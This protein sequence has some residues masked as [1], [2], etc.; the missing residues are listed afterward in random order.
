[1]MPETTP[2]SLLSSSAETAETAS[3]SS[4]DRDS[5]RCRRVPVAHPSTTTTT[6]TTTT[7]NPPS[8][9]IYALD[10]DG[11][12]VDSA[13]E[14]CESA[15]RAC[16]TVWP[17]DIDI[18]LW[19]TP[20]QTNPLV[21]Q[22]VL[23]QFY[24]V[25]PILYVGWEAILLV[26]LLVMQCSSQSNDDSD[27]DNETDDTRVAHPVTFNNSSVISTEDIVKTFHSELKE[28]IM[29]YYNLSIKD[30]NDA[31]AQARN[32]W[33]NENTS[34]DRTTDNQQQQPQPQQRQYH[35]QRVD[36]IAAH[37]F[38]EGACKAVREYLSTHGND[39]IY[40]ITT[41]AKDFT[42]RLLQKQNLYPA[43]N[44]NTATTVIDGDDDAPPSSSYCFLQESHIYGL[45][46]GPKADVLL[47]IMDQ[48]QRQQGKRSKDNDNDDDDDD[49]IAVMIEDNIATLQTIMSM[50]TTHQKKI[51]P[52]VAAW[53]YNTDD[54]L[55]VAKRDG[56][57]LLKEDDSSSL[58]TILDERRV[59]Q[60][61]Q[62]FV[63]S[64]RP[65][66]GVK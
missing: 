64:R 7:T 11:V 29:K 56:Y 25:R 58:S 1:M 51:L 31:F 14:T 20:L 5:D 10:F 50:S 49:V 48:R 66:S 61:Y 26:K 46:S 37:G 18:E 62:E 8:S 9:V 23:Q 32:S 17:D 38:F 13:K 21:F 52:V 63:A 39:S 47:S 33:I 28:Q 54:D 41:K 40:I 65:T 2:Q 42:I 57:H 60:L 6:T 12:L 16:A 15:I 35:P 44:H 3:S 24:M 27:M 36:W 22:H 55:N 45:G 34:V 53:G 43:D 59:Q 4:I 30:C 19:I